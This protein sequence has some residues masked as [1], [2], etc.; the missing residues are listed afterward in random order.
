M[1]SL[2]LFY[3]TRFIQKLIL[4]LLVV[5]RRGHKRALQVTECLPNLSNGNFTLQNFATSEF[6]A[7]FAHMPS[8]IASQACLSEHTHSKCSAWG[9][10]CEGKILLTAK[11]CDKSWSQIQIP[12][13]QEC[14][15]WIVP[16]FWAFEHFTSLPDLRLMRN[17][18]ETRQLV[19]QDLG[20]EFVPCP[21]CF[22]SIIGPW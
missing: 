18:E 22:S 14:S 2:R 1:H 21:A 6:T 15:E 17:V 16:V 11:S 19:R 20:L 12:Q 13:L 5:G 7:G 8:N 10:N 3:F 4:F 9:W